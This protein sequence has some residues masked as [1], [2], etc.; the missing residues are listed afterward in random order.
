VWW[1]RGQSR[2]KRAVELTACEFERE[3]RQ[4][5]TPHLEAPEGVRLVAHDEEHGRQQV[6]HALAVAQVPV[7][8]RVGE[9]H[10]PQRGGHGGG[11]GRRRRGT[12]EERMPPVRTH[13]RVRVG[14]GRVRVGQGSGK[15][16]RRSVRTY[17]MVWVRV[18]ELG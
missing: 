4:R 16:C 17:V 7:E 9:Q 8:E 15:W 12:R 11:R 2:S 13:L 18:R 6:A 3:M 5:A 14:V 1:V 10:G